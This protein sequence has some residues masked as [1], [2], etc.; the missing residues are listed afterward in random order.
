MNAEL[1][2]YYLIDTSKLRDIGYQD[3]ENLVSK[4][5][6]CQNLHFLVAKKAH[7]E[8]HPDFERWLNKAA[9]YSTDRV[10][11]YQLLH[12]VDFQ[13]DYIFEGEKFDLGE[14]APS[15]E[16]AQ[17]TELELENVHIEE[18]ELE[19]IAIEKDYFEM[20]N[21]IAAA[22]PVATI[23][24]IIPSQ[25]TDNQDISD[26]DEYEKPLMT[27]SDLMQQSEK[28]DVK[29]EV[30]E[31][32]KL[33]TFADLIQ[34]NKEEDAKENVKE[35]EEELITFADLMQ[36]N[37]D[38]E[39]KENIEEEEETLMTFEQLLQQNEPFPN[40]IETEQAA[41]VEKILEKTKETESSTPKKVLK[42]TPKSAFSS[43]QKKSE[44]NDGTNIGETLNHGEEILKVKEKIEKRMESDEDKKKRKEAKKNK[45]QEGMSFV[46]RSLI[47]NENIATE[48]LA[49]I[50]ALQGRKDEAIVMFEKLKLQMPEK[51]TFF[52]L[53]I[54]KLK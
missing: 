48:T 41:L 50:L 51:S 4:F 14:I 7:A 49:K 32:E 54:E 46:D 23:T 28:E 42:P 19:P 45:K 38:A 34:E 6:Y 26:D 20:E 18:K 17:T 37:K 11:L 43:W 22:I 9:T 30:K 13:K 25:H 3:L 52:A 44:T 29:E 8:D 21:V 40:H 27:L 53:E 39:K 31:E 24:A 35:E 47:P 2:S 10:Y 1:F 16:V 15:Q 36:E 12:E 5:P 33:M